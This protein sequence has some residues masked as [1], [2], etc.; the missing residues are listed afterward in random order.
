MR[1]QRIVTVAFLGLL[2]LSGCGRSGHPVAPIMAEPSPPTD[3]TAFVRN[4]TVVL[5]WT[6]PT[7]NIDGTVLKYPPVFRISRQQMAPQPSAS[8]IVASVKAEK[9]ENAVVSGSRYAFTDSQVIVGEKYT[10]VI[11]AVSRRGV[12]GPPSAEATAL[13]TVEI[14]APSNL[15]AEAGERA[16]RLSWGAPTRRIDASPLAVTPRYNIYR[17]I[18][19][20]KYDPTPINREPVQGV[21][22][23]D[24]NLIN[25]QM[26]YYRVTA[27]EGQEPPWH[28]GLPSGEVGIAPVDLTPPAPPQGVRAVTGPGAVVSL[29]WEVNRESDLLGYLVYRSDVAHRLPI[30]VTDAPLKSPILTDRSV[31]SRGRYTYTVTAV[32]ASLRRNESAASPAIEVRVP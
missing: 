1:I 15:R 6:R 9:P 4:R 23:Q 10:Y 31:K 12:V 27:A 19:P 24:A 30:R 2:V 11:E 28:E 17:G 8:S 3:V 25:D 7:T 5:T 29:S 18:S 20:G 14:A 26:Y 32:D 22:F 16:I 21:Q 13:V